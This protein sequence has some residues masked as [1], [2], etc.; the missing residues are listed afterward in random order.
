MKRTSHP[1]DLVKRDFT[2]PMEVFLSILPRRPPRWPAA[3]HRIRPDPTVVR[4]LEP[5]MGIEPMA[6]SLPRMRSTTELQ[7]PFRS[8]ARPF[9]AALFLLILVPDRRL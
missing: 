5:P 1:A 3:S 6:S 9:P 7:G 2:L 8:R 4:I